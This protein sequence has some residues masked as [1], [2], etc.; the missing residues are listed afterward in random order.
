LLFVGKPMEN[1]AIGPGDEFGNKNSSTF[2]TLTI[3]Q[4]H[5]SI[6]TILAGVLATHGPKLA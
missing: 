5:I 1:A 3:V 2:S 4:M 6:K